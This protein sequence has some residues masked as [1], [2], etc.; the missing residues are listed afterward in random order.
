MEQNEKPKAPT[1]VVVIL[2]AALLPRWL[3]D[4]AQIGYK[5]REIRDMKRQ[6]AELQS[7]VRSK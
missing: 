3:I 7:M 4:T 2:L 1:W 5:D 6:I